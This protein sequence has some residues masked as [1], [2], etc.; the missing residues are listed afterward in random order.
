MD[1]IKIKIPNKIAYKTNI[2]I[3]IGDINY[4]GHLSNDAVLRIAHEARIR[5]LETNSMREM[6]VGGPGLIMSDAAIQYMAEAFRGNNLLVEIT[7]DNV[8]KM[9]FDL[10]YNISF[11][12]N[13]KCVAK[14]KTGL[15]FFDYTEHKLIHAPDVL[16]EKF[17]AF[18][19]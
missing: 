3:L 9:G 18:C 14:V 5:F 10:Y 11:S 7:V 2:D 17:K 6:D 19:K 15:L 4:G 1:R 16:I 12:N 13:L 8:S